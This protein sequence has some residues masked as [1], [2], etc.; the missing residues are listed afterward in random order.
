MRG[1]RSLKRSNS[2][3]KVYFMEDR[4]MPLQKI[5]STDAPAAVT[6]IRLIVGAVFL[7][8]GI[9]KFLFPDE[10]GVGRFIKIGIP[11]PD[12]VAPFVGVCEIVCGVLV[13]IGLLTRLATIPLII[14]M[15]VAISATKIPILLKSGFWAMAHEARVDYAMLLGSIFLFLVGAGAWSVDAPLASWTA[16]RNA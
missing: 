11:T 6:L 1:A 3:P 10:L 13:F 15:V 12:V 4:T 8:E 14:D 7:S 9:Q 16:K 2:Y 5:V